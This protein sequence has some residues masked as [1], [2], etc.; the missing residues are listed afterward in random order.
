M[1]DVLDGEIE[2]V[3]VPLWIAAILRP[4]IGQDAL[5]LDLLALKERGSLGH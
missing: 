1:V 4:P 5:E 2:L 3:F